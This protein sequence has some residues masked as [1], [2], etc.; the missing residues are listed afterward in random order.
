M[1]KHILLT[2][3]SLA[4]GNELDNRDDRYAMQITKK[5]NCNLHDVTQSGNCNHL[6]NDYSFEKLNHLIFDEKINPEEILVIHSLSFIN[7]LPVYWKSRDKFVVVK[8]VNFFVYNN[9]KFLNEHPEILYDY[10]CEDSI[11]I[12]DLEM[13]Y[14]LVNDERFLIYNYLRDIMF[15]EMYYRSLNVKVI[16]TEAVKYKNSSLINIKPKVSDL[17]GGYKKTSNATFKANINFNN[18]MS[19]TLL[20]ICKSKKY[21]R[22]KLGHPLEQSHSDF[23]SQLLNFIDKRYKS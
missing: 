16:F 3:C 17:L 5:L 23:A 2:G 11:N 21:P 6:I 13:Y 8:E 22:G 7:R 14:N 10:R 18:F 12:F 15:A 19:D 4:H 9:T 20:N 1:L